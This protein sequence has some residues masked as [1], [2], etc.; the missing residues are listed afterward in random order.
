MSTFYFT[1]GLVYILIGFGATLMFFYGMKKNFP[2]KFLGA[3]VIGVVG[4][5]IGGFIDFFFS[6]I[7]VKLAHIFGTIN[8]FPPLLTAIVFLWAF[9]KIGSAK[10]DN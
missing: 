1:I 10:D 7:L 3:V 4:S 8:I 2:G 9:Y 5:F 6:D